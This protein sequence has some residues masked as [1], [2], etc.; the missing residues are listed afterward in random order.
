MHLWCYQQ[1]HG[2]HYGAINHNTVSMRSNFGAINSDMESVFVLSTIAR[3]VCDA[4]LVLSTMT[5]EDIIK[6]LSCWCMEYLTRSASTILW[7]LLQLKNNASQENIIL[8]FYSA[9]FDWCNCVNVCLINTVYVMKYF[10]VVVHVLL[11][12]SS[13]RYSCNSS[14]SFWFPIISVTIYSLNILSPPS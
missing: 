2:K 5:W 7:I 13:S 14:I 1:W 11:Q 10:A 12:Y 3:K 9:W 6:A 4:S 8:Q